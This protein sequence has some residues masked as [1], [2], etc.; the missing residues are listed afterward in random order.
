MK[1]DKSKRHFISTIIVIHLAGAG[2][3]AQVPIS[4]SADIPR[5]WDDAAISQLEI[6]LANPIGSPKHV[7]SN[8]YYKIP[9]R[10]IYKQ[11][12]VYAPDREPTGYM[13]WLKQQEPLIL[14]N[15]D[16]IRPSLVNDQDWIKGG[17]MVFDAALVYSSE[18]KG[19][20]RMEDVRNNRLPIPRSPDGVEPFLHYVIREKG[21]VELG[22]FS[23]AMCHTR[24]MADGRVVK[25]AQGNLPFGQALAGLGTFPWPA[26]QKLFSVPWLDP[27]PLERMKVMSDAQVRTLLS[28]IPPGVFPRHRGSLLEPMQIPSLMDVKFRHYLD[29]TGLQRNQSLV[30]LMRYAAMNQG[31]D[32]LA[33]FNGFVPADIPTFKAV[34]QPSDPIRGAGRYSDEQLYALARYIYSLK[35]PPNPNAK[36]ASAQRGSKIFAREGC[37]QCHTPPL[38]TN[39]KLTPAS[40][41]TVPADHLTKYEILPVSVG[42]DPDLAMKTRRGTGYYKVPALTG[43]WYRGMFGHS[44]W[45]ATLEDWFNPQRL[46]DDYVPTGFNPRPPHPFAVKGHEYGLNLPDREK[47]DLIQF[48]KTL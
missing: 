30:D 8:Y 18:N 22:S 40:G 35:A 27:D 13:D 33:S 11:Y 4:S 36:N 5:S 39:N 44:G 2:L 20:F 12:P 1:L 16:K 24:V 37:G 28:S 42:T 3:V 10:P 48:L 47:L 15:D 7:S 21:K 34:P 25:G 45:C 43:V 9:V 26:L 46:K 32:F 14:W 6:P 23:C 17:E 41:F 31:A 29:R 38:Y 19:G